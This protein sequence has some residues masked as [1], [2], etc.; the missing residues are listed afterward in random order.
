MDFVCSGG[1]GASVKERATDV[2][3]RYETSNTVR[4]F[5]SLTQQ[6]RRP[7]DKMKDGCCAMREEGREGMR[8]PLALW[9]LW[10]G[11]NFPSLYC[12]ARVLIGG[13]PWDYNS[14]DSQMGGSEDGDR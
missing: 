6:A 13:G 7:A 11:G 8:G 5:L 14:R 10:R 1:S 12:F 2:T 4:Y 3:Y 9:L